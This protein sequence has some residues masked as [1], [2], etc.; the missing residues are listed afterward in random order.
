MSSGF[1]EEMYLEIFF[2]ACVGDPSKRPS[3]ALATSLL[4]ILFKMNTLPALYL[5]GLIMAPGKLISL[6]VYFIDGISNWLDPSSK[7]AC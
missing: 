7:F 5:S 1:F 2:Q 6:A 3:L 4:S